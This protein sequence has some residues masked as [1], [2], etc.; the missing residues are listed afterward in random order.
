MV[1]EQLPPQRKRPGAPDTHGLVQTPPLDLE[2]SGHLLACK[3]QAAPGLR[4]D[5]SVLALAGGGQTL[6]CP[7]VGVRQGD[8]Q[9]RGQ[10]PQELALAVGQV[11][12]AVMSETGRG[13]A[14]V[15]EL[16]LTPASLGGHSPSEQV[17]ETTHLR[18]AVLG[19]SRDH[20]LQ[21]LGGRVRGDGGQDG[22]GLGAP[23]GVAAQGAPGGGGKTL[24]LHPDGEG[25]QPLVLQALPL[26][27]LTVMGDPGLDDEGTQLTGVRRIEQAQVELD[28]AGPVGGLEPVGLEHPVAHDVR[29]E[30][31]PVGEPH[32]GQSLEGEPVQGH[33]RALQSPFG[34][35]EGLRCDD[36]GDVIPVDLQ[37]AQQVGPRET[38][39]LLG[40]GGTQSGDAVGNHQTGQPGRT[41]PA[42]VR[43]RTHHRLKGQLPDLGE[44]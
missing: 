17:G 23:C 39:L 42:H 16:G 25:E 24:T 43:N 13:D 40:A 20:D 7:S 35:C 31:R 10:A 1:G 41:H 2:D 4:H 12:Q 21:G 19:C 11:Q 27:G 18:Q 15:T 37:R 36:V 8:G 33:R 9:L 22:L 30:R 32:L 3:G 26:D 5:L 34:R 14:A 44:T 28:G 38:V 6:A 29:V